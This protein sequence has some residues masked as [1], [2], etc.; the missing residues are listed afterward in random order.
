M[1]IKDS[2]ELSQ[3]IEKLEAKLGVLE[4]DIFIKIFRIKQALDPLENVK[5]LLPRKVTI[6]ET[7]NNLIDKS[8]MGVADLLIYKLAIPSNNSFIKVAGNTVLKNFINRAISKNAFKI[9]AISFA[10]LKNIF[11]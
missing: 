7:F 8:I 6:G 11:I 5:K 4:N 2:K 9:K 1:R 10:I 3:G